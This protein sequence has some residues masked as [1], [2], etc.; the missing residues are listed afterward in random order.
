MPNYNAK[1]GIAFGYIAANALHPDIVDSLIYGHGEQ[2]RDIAWEETLADAIAEYRRENPTETEDMDDG[3]IEDVIRDTLAESMCDA[4]ICVEGIYN[5]VSYASSWLGGALNFWISE[6][7]HITNN[8]RR[9]SPCV[10]GAAIL[11][12]LDGE[13]T[14]YDVPPDWRIGEED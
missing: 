6:S 2:F 8:A 7:P 9:A 12:T 14:G 10:P 4:E 13:E 5:G 3:E 11:D 1:T